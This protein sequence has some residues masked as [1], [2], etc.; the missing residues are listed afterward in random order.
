MRPWST[1]SQSETPSSCPT[2]CPRVLTSYC[3]RLICILSSA[4]LHKGAETGNGPAHNK[5]VHFTGAFVGV[6]GFGIAHETAHLVG[7]QDTLASQQFAGIAHRLAHFRVTE[8]FGQ[9]S[10]FLTPYDR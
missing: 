1:V 8:G 10:V 9:P 5:R 4:L 2:N 3:S 6:N 7:E